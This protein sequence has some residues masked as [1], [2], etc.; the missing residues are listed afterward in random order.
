MKR[1]PKARQNLREGR[2]LRRKGRGTPAPH[3]GRVATAE[4]LPISEIRRARIFISESEA[5]LLH[6]LPEWRAARLAAQRRSVR[7]V[8]AR[9]EMKNLIAQLC[10]HGQAQT[11][12]WSKRALAKH[13][14]IPARTFLRMQQASASP[15][16]YLPRLRAAVAKIAAPDAPCNESALPLHGATA[17]AAR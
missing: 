12:P 2:N 8:S 9:D 15:A 14:G 11:P 5:R 13:T 6:R 4:R 1:E 17:D 16:E 7:K 3:F 10:A